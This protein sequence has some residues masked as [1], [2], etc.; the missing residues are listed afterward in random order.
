GAQKNSKSRGMMLKA[1]LPYP[2]YSASLIAL[3]SMEWLAAMRTRRSAHG[4]LG[5][6]C[7]VNISHS[8]NVGSV[9]LRLRPGVRFTSSAFGPR[10]WYAPSVSPH[11]SIAERGGATGTE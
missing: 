5:S 10:I 8:V 3:R 11:M 1:S 7:S 4:D 2:R 6:H 9:G